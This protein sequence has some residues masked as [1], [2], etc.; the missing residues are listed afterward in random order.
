MGG[1]PDSPYTGG[2]GFGYSAE[3]LGLSVADLSLAVLK[4]AGVL[5]LR[6]SIAVMALYTLMLVALQGWIPAPVAHT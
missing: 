4:D 3:Y 2:L 6:S 5:C 1:H